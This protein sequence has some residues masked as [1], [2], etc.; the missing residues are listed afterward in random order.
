MKSESL[1]V[2][3]EA[4]ADS[5]DQLARLVYPGFLSQTPAEWLPHLPRYLRAM[6]LRPKNPAST[7]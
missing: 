6:A 2:W 5:R 3:A 4:I 1:L 7:G